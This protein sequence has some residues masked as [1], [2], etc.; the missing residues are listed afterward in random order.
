MRSSTIR[1]GLRMGIVTPVYFKDAQILSD[2]DIRAIFQEVLSLIE[3]EEEKIIIISFAKVSL[4]SA[5][6]LGKLMTLDK[7]LKEKGGRSGLFLC[8]IR[9]EVY[10]LFKVTR[11]SRLFKIFPTLLE[12]LTECP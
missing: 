4:V 11:T 1:V 6:I 8:D 12:A 10:V 5:G 2:K 9:P 3:N 7:K